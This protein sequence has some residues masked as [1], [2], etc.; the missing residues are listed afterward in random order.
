MLELV[1]KT[2][3]QLMVE[4]LELSHIAG[5]RVK[6]YIHISAKVHSGYGNH[7]VIWTSKF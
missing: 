3:K 6:Q 4:E 2:L 7:T 1:N 5:R